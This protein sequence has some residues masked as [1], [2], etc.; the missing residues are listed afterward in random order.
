[1]KKKRVGKH[2][3]GGRLKMARVA[4]L[5]QRPDR[6]IVDDDW[7]AHLEP[8]TEEDIAFLAKLDARETG[9]AFFEKEKGGDN[10]GRIPRRHRR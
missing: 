1:M 8:P 6:R 3:K 7:P 9:S 5:M 2:Y 4:A 10:N